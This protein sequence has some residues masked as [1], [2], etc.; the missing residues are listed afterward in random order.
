MGWGRDLLSSVKPS[1][2]CHG[3]CLMEHIHSKGRFVGSVQV[4]GLS[5][6]KTLFCVV[7]I[8]FATTSGRVASF[9]FSSNK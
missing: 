1:L 3:Y 2:I 5:M 6:E 9:P 7:Y 4:G 8:I